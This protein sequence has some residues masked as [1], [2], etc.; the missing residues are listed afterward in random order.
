LEKLGAKTKHTIPAKLTDAA[1][2]VAVQS[3]ESSAQD[4]ADLSAELDSDNTPD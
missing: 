1:G 4:E 3:V 2:V